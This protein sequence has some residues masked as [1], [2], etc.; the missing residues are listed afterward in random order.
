MGKSDV[1]CIWPLAYDYPLFRKQL[2]RDRDLFGK[3]IISFTHNDESND[4]RNFLTEKYPDWTFVDSHEG[5]SDWYDEAVNG[6]LRAS[7]SELVLFLEQDFTYRRFLVEQLLNFLS[8][9]YGT[10][11]DFICYREGGK[12]LH[13][14]FFLARRSCIEKTSKFFGIK[15]DSKI[16]NF[17]FFTKEMEDRAYI[18]RFLDEYPW[19]IPG[20]DYYHMNG[21]THSLRLH[22]EGKEIYYKP[23]EFKKYLEECQRLTSQ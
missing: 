21:L 20:R 19:A 12:R 18:G 7:D 17:D 9:P 22:R 15:P 13:L 10:K 8:G 14:S 3:V 23:E 16:D 11:T 6:A 4:Y 5:K 2:E 1:I